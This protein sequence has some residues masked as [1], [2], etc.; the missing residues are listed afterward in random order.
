MARQYKMPCVTLEGDKV[1]PRGGMDGGYTDP[2]KSRLAAVQTRNDNRAK[3]VELEAEQKSI[4][5]Q[6]ADIEQ[7]VTKISGEISV[8]ERQHSDLKL[9]Q[10]DCRAMIK[11]LML[12]IKD[13]ERA[14]Q[15]QG[16][17]L[18]AMRDRHGDLD[19]EIRTMRDEVGTELQAELSDQDRNKLK[20]LKREISKLNQQVCA[21]M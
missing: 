5:E 11:T 21:R 8:L 7:S 9:L 15:R 6:T 20:K 3:L 18:K 4:N 13:A 17:D 12:A 16:G 14:I 2:R 1:E 19:A 10:Q